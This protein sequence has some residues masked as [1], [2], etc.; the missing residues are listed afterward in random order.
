MKISEFNEKIEELKKGESRGYSAAVAS[1]VTANLLN[2]PDFEMPSYSQGEDGKA[3]VTTTTPVKNFR[4]ATAGVVSKALGLDKAETAALADKMEFGKSYG[5]A[6]NNA[7]DAAEAVYLSTGRARVKPQIG[8]DVTRVSI[9]L[10]AIP[11]KTEE[12]SKIVN[13]GGQYKSVPTGN[14]V[15]TK[16][17]R[18]AKVKNSVRPWQKDIRSK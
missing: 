7:A 5:E 3:V 11:E 1:E 17:H 4:N 15:T 16:E 14:I 9:R 12:T 18:A 6:F 13:E 2:T 10:E 8:D